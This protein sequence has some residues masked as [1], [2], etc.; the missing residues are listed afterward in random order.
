MSD[1]PRPFE[2]A[3]FASAVAS[4]VTVRLGE[5]LVIRRADGDYIARCERCEAEFRVPFLSS[6]LAAAMDAGVAFVM[7]HQH[8]EQTS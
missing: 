1:E 6:M 4:G 8:R 2:P 7:K 5:H 3:E